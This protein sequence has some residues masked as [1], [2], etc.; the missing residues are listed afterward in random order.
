MLDTF[1]YYHDGKGIELLEHGCQSH[2]QRHQTTPRLGADSPTGLGR[3]DELSEE[4]SI[5]LKLT[6]DVRFMIQD[7]G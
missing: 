7:L 1:L 3:S 5:Y 4:G 6:F 2:A